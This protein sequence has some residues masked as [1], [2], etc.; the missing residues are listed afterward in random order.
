[1]SSVVTFNSEV[2]YLPPCVLSQVSSDET[3]IN[4]FGVEERDLHI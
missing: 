1:M 3:V 4:M 2:V